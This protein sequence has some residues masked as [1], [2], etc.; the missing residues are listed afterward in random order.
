MTLSVMLTGYDGR[1]FSFQLSVPSRNESTVPE[2]TQ[3]ICSSS[4]R[5]GVVNRTIMTL[6]TTQKQ[7]NLSEAI[8]CCISTPTA[9][10]KCVSYGTATG[11]GKTE[12]WSLD[13]RA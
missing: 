3:I 8:T 1:V 7:V 12:K 9:E 6:N 11:I 2:G 5:V 4:N 10:T 13:K